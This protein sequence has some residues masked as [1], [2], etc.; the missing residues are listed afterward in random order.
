VNEHIFIT[1]KDEDIAIAR[2]HQLLKSGRS[3][4]EDIIVAAMDRLIDWNV[5]PV[6]GTGYSKRLNKKVFGT[7]EP[8]IK[9][10]E[11][12]RINVIRYDQR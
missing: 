8:V 3:L 1:I 4:N 2:R 9:A 11:K 12:F 5:G 10:G 6:Y 7:S